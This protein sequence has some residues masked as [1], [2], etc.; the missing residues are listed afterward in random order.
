MSGIGL[1]GA[2][3]VEAHTPVRNTIIV[4]LRPGVFHAKDLVLNVFLSPYLKSF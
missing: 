4:S 1:L 2:T 3:G